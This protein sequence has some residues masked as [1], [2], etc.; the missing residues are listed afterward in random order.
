MSVW[1][2]E[3]SEGDEGEEY[4]GEEKPDCLPWI[5]SPS[6]EAKLDE[7]DPLGSVRSVCRP[8]IA[9][10]FASALRLRPR[11][12]FGRAWTG[13]QRRALARTQAWGSQGKESEEQPVSGI[14]LQCSRRL[15]ERL[16][17]A[18]NADLILLI[19]LRRYERGGR[20][21]HPHSDARF[22]HT[23]AV[24]RIAKS[25]DCKYYKGCV[26]HPHKPGRW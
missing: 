5:V 23:I 8:R 20:F 3:Y 11:D 18:A 26:N 6:M 12:P 4:V 1:L 22:S 2:P 24:L 9:K 15:L 16:L 14:R 10:A 13:A 21:G 7:D 25:L 17:T 19:K